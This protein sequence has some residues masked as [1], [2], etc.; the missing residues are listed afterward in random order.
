MDARVGER[1]RKERAERDLEVIQSTR[2]AFLETLRAAALDGEI[3]AAQN[4]FGQP[5]KSASETLEVVP[6]PT[7]QDRLRALGRPTFLIGLASGLNEQPTRISGTFDTE[8]STGI[9]TPERARS[10]LMLGPLLALSLAAVKRRRHAFVDYLLMTGFLGILAF[11]GGPLA[12]ATGLMIAAAGWFSRPRHQLSSPG[13]SLPAR[14]HSS[15]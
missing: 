1:S 6:E 4:Y 10:L 12:F 5:R 14:Q 7:G 15:G 3:E 13:P 9:E 8:S 11:L 2:K